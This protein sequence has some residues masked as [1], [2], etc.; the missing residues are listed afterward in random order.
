MSYLEEAIQHRSAARQ[1]RELAEEFDQTRSNDAARV[2]RNRAND[3]ERLADNA[4]YRGRIS[5]E[6]RELQMDELEIPMSSA[7]AA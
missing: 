1:F 5:D 2:A 3:E 6:Q 4:D 7:R